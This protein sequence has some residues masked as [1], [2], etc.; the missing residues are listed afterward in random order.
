MKIH[1][2]VSCD[3]IDPNKPPP[4]CCGCDPVNVGF[5]KMPPKLADAPNGEVD[6]W[7]IDAA[8][9]NDEPQPPNT[10]CFGCWSA[11]IVVFSTPNPRP[12]NESELVGPLPSMSASKSL[13]FKKY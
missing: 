1:L 7:V 3:V 9:N 6:C 5:F 2:P 13:G 10:F 12:P 11:E 4:A 8:P